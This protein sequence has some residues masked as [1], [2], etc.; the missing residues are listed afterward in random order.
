[1]NLYFPNGFQCTFKE[2]AARNYEIDTDPTDYIAQTLTFCRD[3]LLG[4]ENFTIH[5]SGSTGAPKPIQISR[6]QMEAS[7]QATA[8][9]LNLQ[10]GDTALVSLN[11]SYIAGKMMLVRGLQIEMDMIIVEPSADPLAIFADK[12]LIRDIDFSAFVPLQL[13]TI[14]ESEQKEANLRLL[15]KMKAIIIGGAPVNA[16]LENLLQNIQA[17]VYATYGMTETVSHIALKKLNGTDKSP[18]YQ[19]LPATEIGIDERDCLTI[20]SPVT[21][22]EKIITNDKV[23]LV[24]NKQFEW[25]GRVDNVVNSGGVKIQIEKVENEVDKVFLELNLYCRFVVIGLPDANLG[26]MLVLVLEQ[27]TVNNSNAIIDLLKQKLT[28]YEVPKK[29]IYLSKFPETATHKI[30]RLKIRQECL[31]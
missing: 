18:Y 11:T 28:K 30:D 3:W 22:F 2:I 20:I 9:A 14:L 19:A 25:L 17:P 13:L 29:I 21:N 7:A 8:Q 10:K 5:T 12:S 31:S 6:K 4:K 27:V 1:M 24:S 16:I 15:N 23:K 26:E